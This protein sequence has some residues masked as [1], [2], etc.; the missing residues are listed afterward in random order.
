MSRAKPGSW[1][2]R[3]VTGR[4]NAVYSPDGPAWL[5]LRLRRPC[6]TFDFKENTMPETVSLL[7]PTCQ[8]LLRYTARF[9]GRTCRCPSCG[10]EVLV[11]PR[12][13]NQNSEDGVLNKGRQPS[14]APR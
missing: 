9:V 12:I 10:H 6:L 2:R 8:N 4:I 14:A 13:L 1:K 7:C 5:R 11:M 3:D